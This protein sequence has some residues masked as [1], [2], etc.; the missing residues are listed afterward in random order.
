M[1]KVISFFIFFLL[2][3]SFTLP[4]ESYY[5]GAG[6]LGGYRHYRYYGWHHPRFFFGT[7]LIVPWYVPVAPP[8]YV[9]TRP[10]VYSPPA[11]NQAYAYP[12]PEFIAKYKKSENP[13]G[14]WVT[15]PGQWVD[16]TWVPPHKVQVPI[17]P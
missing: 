2:V 14:E 6:H 10:V 3:L 1:K 5:R 15:V 9:Y 12:D 11:Q 17:N 16:N 13:P 7:S 8:V 4:A